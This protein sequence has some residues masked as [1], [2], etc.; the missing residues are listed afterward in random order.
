MKKNVLLFLA[1]FLSLGAWA[2]DFTV[3]GV[4]YTI[5]DATN[6]YVSIGTGSNAPA[7]GT[8]TVGAF[9][10]PSSVSYNDITYSVTAIGGYAFYYCSGLTSVTI[11]NSVTSIGEYAFYKC[12]LTSMDIPGSVTSIEKAAFLYCTS[13]TSLTIPN[14]V[15]SIG[16]SA[17]YNCSGLT[18]LTI[19]NSVTS[20]EN[21]AFTY[22]SGLTS[23]TISNSVTTIADHTFYGCSSLTSITI[24]NS[25]T[26]IMKYAFYQCSSLVS[27]TVPSSVTFI[28][29]VA[30]SNCSSLESFYINGNDPS[31]IS[32]EA[33]VFLSSPVTT[34]T[35][36]VPSGSK[37]L[38]ASAWQWSDF[39]NIE[40][41]T[42]T[43][44]ASTANIAAAAYSTATI[45]VTSSNTT[46]SV[47][48]DQPWLA[49]TPDSGDS[50]T[51]LTLVAS[52]NHTSA[53][54]TATVTVSSD[55]LDI[56]RT[57]EVT[58]TTAD[59]ALDFD[60]IDDFVNC[61]VYNPTSF[62]M[63]AWVYPSV[64]NVDQ[65][66]VSTLSG[67]YGTGCE[68][69]IGSDGIP[70]F[71]I[72][73]GSWVDTKGTDAISAQKWTHLAA[74]YDGSTIK[75]YVNGELA[76]STSSSVYNPSSFE[77]FIGR[78]ASDLY[79]FKGAID[80]LRV[81][82][83]ALS[84]SQIEANMYN[85]IE[86]PETTDGLMLYYQFNQGT[87]GGNNATITSLNDASASAQNGTLS[88]FA[89]TGS[90]SNWVEGCHDILNVSSFEVSI[91]AAANSTDTVRVISNTT[92]ATSID[93][94]WLSVDPSSGS[95]NDTLTFTAVAN[96]YARIRKA[97]V[98]VSADHVSSR[99]VTVI[100][101]AGAPTL[102]VSS[103]TVSIDA[104]A[105]S[106]ATVDVNSN[107]TWT[108]SSDQT[109]LSLSTVSATD[110][111]TLTLTAL[112]NPTVVSRTATITVSATGVT[113]QTITVTQAAGEATLNVSSSAVSVD[114]YASSATVDVTSNTTWTTSSDQAW[115]TV[116][117]AS[118][119]GNGTITLAAE[120][121]ATGAER[122]ATITVF[123]SN[124]VNRT[125]TVTQPK[126][127]LSVSS[128]TVSIGGT[129]NSTATIDVTSNTTWTASSDQAW[130]T[131]DPASATGNGTLTLTA[132]VNPIMESRTATITVSAT[133]VASQ[134][135]MVT[136][137]AGAATLGVSSSNASIGGTANST[138]TVDVTSNTTWTASSDQ[139]W[140]TVS[141]ESATGNGTL[142]LTASVNPTVETRTATI[143]V[144]ATGVTSQTI[145]VTQAAGEAV[146]SV[147]SST[148]SIGGPANSTATID[149]TSNVTWIASSSQTWLAVSPASA[150]GNGTLTLTASAN[151]VMESRTAI[152]T[153]LSTAT[154]SQTITVT[155]AAGDATLS[156]SSSTVIISETA[157]SSAMLQVFSNT[158]WTAS[159]SETW[160]SVSPA[161]GA[162]NAT[163]TLTAL[164]DNPVAES[165]TATVTVSA[166]GAA[167]Q[168]I[169]VSQGSGAVTLSVS[170][171]SVSIGASANSTNTVDITSNATWTATSNQTWLSVSP[172][173]ASGDGMLTF[174]AEAN[175]TG[176]ERIA[177]VTVS[178]ADIIVQGVTVTQAAGVD[179]I[180]ENI[181]LGSINIYPNPVVNELTI[182]VK[183]NSQNVNFE[184]VDIN[185]KV[186]CNGKVTEKTILSTSGFA[187]GMYILKL[188]S[189]GKIK[190]E[191]IV[192]K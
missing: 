188:E 96:P 138:T 35:L 14:S 11:P 82:N 47:S 122:T 129:D 147:S 92:W 182:E 137:D 166:T 115:L 9:T 39:T 2:T 80:E 58:Q 146:L 1:F 126:G 97:S 51:V 158:T 24:P 68:L 106:T 118:A 84:Q 52:E 54:R 104:A 18:S 165:R 50:D 162:G 87:A 28:G 91:G 100:Q 164:T 105:S 163:I 7:I 64:V 33:S 29:N 38:Y 62:T 76:G 30:F 173:S 178:A 103:P 49:A 4:A 170:S 123:V 184:I 89:L 60:G 136:Q 37:T 55:M 145:T 183:D 59:N 156:V 124:D 101:D 127:L 134:T 66:I 74:T 135:V 44:S 111:V 154:G 120:T 75:V 27:V 114:T 86:N 83:S 148:V 186:V 12:G 171:N 6:K 79:Y 144:S 157:N 107:T 112:A 155:Q 77:T 46:W 36:Y 149:V 110:S 108:A 113:S 25:V 151:P 119:T 71:S 161:S 42:L 125:I 88:N 176:A 8:S 17:F 40:E 72:S 65:A 174:T 81:W 78:R 95:D 3:D 48:S 130:L 139:T 73:N 175:T 26:S 5:T 20:I 189:L 142:T 21:Y 131:V 57:I 181:E 133:G 32:L 109:W 152:V 67:I 102:S 16:G 43:V 143:T 63:E 168:T 191:K 169:I 53:S 140:L 19:P 45:D 34:C 56:T 22:C 128:S 15:T 10:I 90:A 167:S 93:P 70:V 41:V 159:S 179:I 13:L 177:T 185:G 187:P 172:A 69:H 31:S 153:V 61:G 85:D 160:L 98:I 117:P 99:T 180:N 141:P 150:T 121:N 192:K 94:S 190:Y 23:L 116:D 132:S